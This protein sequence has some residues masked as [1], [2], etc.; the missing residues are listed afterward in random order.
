MEQHISNLKPGLQKIREGCYAKIIRA[1]CQEFDNWKYYHGPPRYNERLKEALSPVGLKNFIRINFSC[2]STEV[3]IPLT[4]FSLVGEHG[5]NFPILQLTEKGEATPLDAGSFISLVE[6]EVGKKVPELDREDVWRAIDDFLGKAC[7]GD[8]TTEN[9]QSGEPGGRFFPGNK[10]DRLEGQNTDK[11]DCPAK[12]IREYLEKLLVERTEKTLFI[13]EGVSGTYA[14]EASWLERILFEDL[15]P[16]I[17]QLGRDNQVS[18]RTSLKEI[19]GC[20]EQYSREQTDPFVERV[21]TARFLMRPSPLLSGH[22]RESVKVLNP[23]HLVFNLQSILC[24]AL[25]DPVFDRYFSEEKVRVTIRPLD[26]DRDLEMLHDWFHREH[27]K[28]IWQMDWTIDRLEDFY[29]ELLPD[30]NSHSYIGEVNGEPIFNVEVYW[31]TR[32]ILGDYYDVAPDDYG[33]HLFIAPVEKLKKRSSLVSQAIVDWLFCHPG[34]K[35]LV[36]EGSVDS[37]PALMNKIHL[38]FKLQGV[39]EMPH[40]KANLN[41][42]YREWYWEKFPANRNLAN[43]ISILKQ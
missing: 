26:L 43:Y 29:R 4:Y 31:P 38:G 28:P 37:L 18:E 23:L 33:T 21:L 12:G 6:A 27:A 17:G 41:I 7:G 3:F 5:I 14:T 40:K 25:T 1:Y 15:L 32:D 30:P 35:R 16:W 9:I 8:K 24:P 39:I 20:L 36:G 10:V 2:S 11:R 13:H 19:S 34:I 22:R 42:C